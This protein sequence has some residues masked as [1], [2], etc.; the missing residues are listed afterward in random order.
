MKIMVAY[1]S[2][3][4]Q[5]EVPL[6][7]EASCTIAIAIRRSGLL[8]QFPEIKLSDISVGVYS[9][10]AALDDILQEND[11][12]EIYR[13]LKIDPKEARLLRAKRAKKNP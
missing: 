12:V 6:E 10:A 7:V 4:R 3:D 2:E 9:R 5:V 1:A 11:R 8:E 13:P